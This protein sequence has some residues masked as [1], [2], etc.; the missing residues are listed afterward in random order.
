MEAAGGV[1]TPRVLMAQNRDHVQD[2]HG[3]MVVNHDTAVDDA[4]P[5][6]FTAKGRQLT[7]EFNRK[8]RHFLLPARRQA[9]ATR[10]FLLQPRSQRAAIVL[11]VIFVNQ[12]RVAI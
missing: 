12:A 4:A 5:A 9:S 10:K 1:P 11:P 8:R 2:G 7:F 6:F 3:S